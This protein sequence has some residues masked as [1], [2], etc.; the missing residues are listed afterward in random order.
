[1]KSIKYISAA[2]VLSLTL[3]SCGDEFLD[4]DPD[5]RIEIKTIGQVQQLLTSAY[6]A[7]NYGW[8]CELSS[9]NLMDNNAPH[10]P[11][12]PN[13]KQVLVH[14]NLQP[15]ERMDD[16]IFR[17]EQVKSS[18]GTDSPS[19]IWENCYNAIA[20]A[21]HCLVYLDQIEEQERAEAAAIGQNYTPSEDERAARGEALLIRAYHHFILVNIFSQAYKNDQASSQ[22]IGIPYITTPEDKVLVHYERGTVTETYN[23]IREDMEAGLKLVSNTYYQMPKW[24]FNVNAAHAFAARFYLYTRDY[25][26]V[27]EH[28]NAVLGEGTGNL[29]NLL[30][31]YDLFDNCTYGDDYANVW[32]SANLNNNLML[33]A[34]Y[35][36]SSRR[37]AG[38]RYGQISTA[39]QSTIYHLGPNWRWY[40]IP[41]AYVSGMTFYRSNQDYGF[42]SMKCGETFEYTDK[43]AGIGYAHVI[44]REFTCT[45]LLLE[46]AEAKLLKQNPDIDGCIEDLIAYDTS[47]WTFTEDDARTFF[48]SNALT[49][50]TRPVLE[51]YYKDPKNYNCFENWDF[52]QNMSP[53]FVVPQDRVVYMNAINDMRRYETNWEGLRFFDLKRWGVEY[54]HFYSVDN[55]EY[56]LTW[57]DPRRAIEI[58]QEVMAAGLEPSRPP[59]DIKDLQQATTEIR[60]TY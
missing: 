51:S 37:A 9:D 41:C 14:Y 11:A 33:M 16:E 20:T 6:G 56:K 18:T 5:E 57:N 39:L 1:M 58:P 17:F 46:R 2:V 29:S 52:T 49:Y 13:D 31:T 34:T 19:S 27:I 22:D 43:V 47:R 24:H 15:Y 26:K 55:I 36:I 8:L 4:K 50:L 12:S 28:A 44:R 32:Q 42:M 54:S 48:A 30:M 59:M 60:K 35:S 21:N 45:E 23:K 53:D 38:Y 7:C 3:V 40:V 25:E 10:L